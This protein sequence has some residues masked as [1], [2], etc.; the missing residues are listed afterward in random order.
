M[1]LL[2]PRFLADNSAL[3]RMK[4]DSVSAVLSPLITAGTV[5][6]CGSFELEFLFSAR[7]FAD[8]TATRE[9]LE[10]GHP[11]VPTAEVDFE[12]ALDAACPSAGSIA[13]ESRFRRQSRPPN[14]R[15][16]PAVHTER[17][18]PAEPGTSVSYPTRPNPVLG[19]A[20]PAERAFGRDRGPGAPAELPFP[21]GRTATAPGGLDI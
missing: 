17:S 2:Q 20:R 3:S 6:R 12:R 15:A 5:A 10:L 11:P 13:P 21:R 7:S 19:D 1:P 9:R 18:L 4:H 8:F 14:Q 16:R